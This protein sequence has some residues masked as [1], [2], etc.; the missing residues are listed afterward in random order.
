MSV[1]EWLLGTL[2][3]LAVIIAVQIGLVWRILASFSGLMNRIRDISMEVYN[4][5]SRLDILLT[6]MRLWKNDKSSFGVKH[7]TNMDHLKDIKSS[8]ERAEIINR[9]PWCFFGK[10]GSCGRPNEDW[11]ACAECIEKWLDAPYEEDKKR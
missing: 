5:R 1:T 9:T 3:V 8:K 4:I 6:H 7:E 11:D 2:C 10:G